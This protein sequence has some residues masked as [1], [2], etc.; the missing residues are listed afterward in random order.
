MADFVASLNAVLWSTP[1]IYTL[2]GIGL[3]FSIV[4]RFL[5]V[6]HIKEMI[7][8][9]FQGKSSE[10]GVS[11][12]QAL[13]IALSGRV[14]TGNI[15]GVATA[16]AFG[17]PGAVFW[18]WAIAFIGASSAFVESTLAQIYKVKQGGQYRGGPAYYIEKGLG[19]KWFAVL[20]A[21]VGTDCNGSPYAR[22]PVQLHCAGRPKCI[23]HISC[24]YW[25]FSCS[26]IRFYHFRRCKTYCQCDTNDCPVYGSRIHS[27]LPDHHCDEYF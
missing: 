8:L 18:M 6:R 1:V 7:V 9:M 12:F 13:S 19:I 20:F 4:T 23:R 14:G 11:S 5:Q 3:I 25:L 22:G 16:I 27:A 17:G 24:H 15:A 2:L 26:L 10:A 21:V